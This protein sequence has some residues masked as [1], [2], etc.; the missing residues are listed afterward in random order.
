VDDLNR[1]LDEVDGQCRKLREEVSSK[2]EE[3][4][5][6]AKRRVAEISALDRGL[7]GNL[8][9]TTFLLSLSGFWLSAASMIICW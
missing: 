3:L 6:T 7:V 5:A 8:F 2:S 9:F 4:T 1:R